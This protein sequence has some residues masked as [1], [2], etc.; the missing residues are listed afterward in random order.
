MFNVLGSRVSEE[1]GLRAGQYIEGVQG[2]VRISDL[3][4]LSGAPGLP[5]GEQKCVGVLRDSNPRL[6]ELDPA[7]DPRL[8]SYLPVGKMAPERV[9]ASSHTALALVERSILRTVR[10]SS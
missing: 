1:D 10:S 5:V 3:G 6:R 8:G 7:K 9:A 2:V 4:W